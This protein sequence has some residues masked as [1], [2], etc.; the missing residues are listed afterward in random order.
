MENKIMKRTTL[1]ILTETN[2][3]HADYTVH[4]IWDAG[5]WRTHLREEYES[6]GL[7]EEGV[8]FED[9]AA[10]YAEGEGRD[11]NER[12]AVGDLVGVSLTEDMRDMTREDWA[13]LER[14]NAARI[15]HHG[16]IPGGCDSVTELLAVLSETE[17]A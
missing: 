9:Y 17:A 13:R 15:V 8:E 10:D 2:R 7:D 5:T 14:S 6:S 16:D 11:I 4:M 12:V 3:R 1:D